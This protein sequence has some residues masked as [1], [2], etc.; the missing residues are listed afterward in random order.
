M[1]CRKCKWGGEMESDL[2]VTVELMEKS[3]RSLK[4]G[5]LKAKFSVTERSQCGRELKEYHS[6]QSDRPKALKQ[7][8]T[9][10]LDGWMRQRGP[11][12]SA[13]VYT[14]LRGGLYSKSRRKS[15][16]GLKG[17]AFFKKKMIILAA[18]EKIDCRVLVLNFLWF[19][20][21]EVLKKKKK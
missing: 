7:K 5:D 19:V 21:D 9:W 15:L 10:N 20:K 4:W 12:S 1:L 13:L 8:Q 11:R 16:E 6:R 17:A 18:V 2:M 14:S 3:Q